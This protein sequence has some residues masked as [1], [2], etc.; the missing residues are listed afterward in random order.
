MQV[1]SIIILSLIAFKLIA[2]FQANNPRAP[3]ISSNGT[4]IFIRNNFLQHAKSFINGRK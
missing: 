3:Q 1:S 2:K 4:I